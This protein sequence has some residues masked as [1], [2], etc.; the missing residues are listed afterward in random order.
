[1]GVGPVV[2]DPRPRIFLCRWRG[3]SRFTLWHVMD[4]LQASPALCGAEVRG[5]EVQRHSPVIMQSEPLFEDGNICKKCLGVAA[6]DLDAQAS[7]HE[8]SAT[9]LRKMR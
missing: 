4:V 8:A 6:A 9:K 5:V 2:N 7:M 1:M 3:L